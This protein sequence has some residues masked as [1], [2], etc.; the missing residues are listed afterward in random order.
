[1]CMINLLCKMA[2]SKSHF[3]HPMRP[4]NSGTAVL[5]PGAR[6][7]TSWME[8][9]PAKSTATGLKLVRLHMISSRSNRCYFLVHAGKASEMAFG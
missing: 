6:A 8:L 3:D 2:P 9:N 1:M 4:R 7:E 5:P